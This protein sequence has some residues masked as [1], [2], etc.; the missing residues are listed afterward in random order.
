M[1]ILVGKLIWAAGV[2]LG[3]VIRLP[4]Q[5]RNRAIRIVNSRADLQ[6]KLLLALVY[7]G[8]VIIPGVYAVS[9]VFSF[10]DYQP[11]LWVLVVGGLLNVAALSLFYLS[12][13][14]LGKNWSQSLDVRDGHK[15]VS[16]GIYSSIRHPMYTAFI[17]TSIAQIALLPN[18]VAGFAGFPCFVLMCI[19]RIPR[20]E[21]MMKEHFGDEYVQYMKKTKRLVPGIL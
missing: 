2:I 11:Q 18:F 8:M 10:A 5:K 15:L 17:L 12:H 4:H 3:Q 13:S 9:S 14:Q 21:A 7:L 20:E 6:E 1:E 16:S 19:L